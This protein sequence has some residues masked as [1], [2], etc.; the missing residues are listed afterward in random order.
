MCECG[1]CVQV[2]FLKRHMSPTHQLRHKRGKVQKNR[3]L[4]AFRCILPFELFLLATYASSSKFYPHEWVSGLVIVS[5]YGTLSK[6]K[7]GKG[8]NFVKTGV[9]GLP[10]LTSMFLLFF[11]KCDCYKME[12]VTKKLVNWAKIPIL[13]GRGGGVD[14]VSP[15]GKNSHIFPFF[16]L[17]SFV[18]SF[19]VFQFVASGLF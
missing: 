10:N 2:L 18:K 12:K 11:Y 14:G 17:I 1:G 15:Y 16:I 3:A 13:G 6:W 5:N 7:T 19:K 9:G 4:S 8:G